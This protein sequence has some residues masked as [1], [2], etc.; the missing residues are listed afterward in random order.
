[1]VVV[2][3]LFCFFVVLVSSLV[4]YASSDMKAIH[5]KERQSVK[6]AESPN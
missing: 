3:V 4:I 2:E 5:K 6:I 1:M